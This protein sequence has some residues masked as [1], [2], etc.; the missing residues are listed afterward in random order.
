MRSNAPHHGENNG[1]KTN[2]NS[3]HDLIRDL[4]G[5][6]GSRGVGGDNPY[7]DSFMNVHSGGKGIQLHPVINKDG[8]SPSPAAMVNIG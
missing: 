4:E 7:V 3:L 8:Y 6:N 1:D 5:D 2:N